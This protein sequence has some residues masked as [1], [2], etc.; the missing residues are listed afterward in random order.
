MLRTFAQQFVHPTRSVTQPLGKI[1][2]ELIPFNV[3]YIANGVDRGWI[4]D[5]EVLDLLLHRCQSLT[6][7]RSLT[8]SISP[9]IEEKSVSIWSATYKPMK[10][11]WSLGHL[12]S[13]QAR[14]GKQTDSWLQYTW[15][16]LVT[17]WTFAKS[18]RLKHVLPSLFSFLVDL[19]YTNALA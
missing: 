9:A 14:R 13:G 15:D 5:K 19:F 6:V 3:I 8:E 16:Q 18:V 12:I 2:V 17:K 4:S 10:R 11:E 7:T 1:R